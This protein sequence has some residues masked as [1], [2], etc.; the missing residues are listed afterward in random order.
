[1]AQLND[2]TPLEENLMSFS[3]SRPDDNDRPYRELAARGRDEY[4]LVSEQYDPITRVTTYV[5]GEDDGPPG[6]P[7]E[8]EEEETPVPYAGPDWT[9]LRVSDGGNRFEWAGT[10]GGQREVSRVEVHTGQRT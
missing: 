9:T 3:M 4:R 10:N 2:F 6:V 5:F 7:I 1:L 8:S